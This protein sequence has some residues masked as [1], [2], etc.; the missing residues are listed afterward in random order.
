MQPVDSSRPADTAAIPDSDHNADIKRKTLT[1]KRHSQ[2]LREGIKVLQGDS[3]AA[4]Q[5]KLDALKLDQTLSELQT[6]STSMGTLGDR[7]SADLDLLKTK[8]PVTEKALSVIQGN[9]DKAKQNLEDAV[10][11]RNGITSTLQATDA[12]HKRVE[13]SHADTQRDQNAIRGQM[14]KL[15]KEQEKEA[16]SLTK[17]E[18]TQKKTEDTAKK[19]GA[20]NQEVDQRLAAIK[21]K[22]DEITPQAETIAQ[23]QGEVHITI[24]GIAKDEAHI[25]AAGKRIEGDQSSM[26]STLAHVNTVRGDIREKASAIEKDQAHIRDDHEKIRETARDIIQI[27]SAQNV[28]RDGMVN[29][30]QGGLERTANHLRNYNW[31]QLLNKI[32]QFVVRII[33]MVWATIIH[34]IIPA[35]ISFKN[36]LMSRIQRTH[37]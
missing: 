14:D 35:V 18:H 13:Q 25:E 32:L 4:A 36:N 1:V 30:F 8:E 19:V 17:T 5:F 21:E 2:N 6:T 7:L 31:S 11:A 24:K 27:N 10:H 16:E 28:P 9:N 20:N 26:Q 12:A 34:K 37:T 29:R 33:A 22:R 23:K 3:S 15:N